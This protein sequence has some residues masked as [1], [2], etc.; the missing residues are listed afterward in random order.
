M[1]RLSLFRHICDSTATS[2]GTRSRIPTQ[3]IAQRVT[4]CDPEAPRVPAS[5]IGHAIRRRA[6][7]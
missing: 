1:P 4:C 7:R 2:V 3:A 5:Q 6:Q